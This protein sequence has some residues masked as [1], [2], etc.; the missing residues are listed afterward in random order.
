MSASINN[1]VVAQYR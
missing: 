1:A